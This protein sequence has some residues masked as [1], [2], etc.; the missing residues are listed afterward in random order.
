M[1]P[2]VAS[3]IKIPE[4]EALEFINNDNNVPEKELYTKD[5][6]YQIFKDLDAHHL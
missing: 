4:E 2:Y 5:E 1:L 6:F 3:K